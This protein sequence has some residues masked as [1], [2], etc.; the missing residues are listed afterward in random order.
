MQIN[1]HVLF[2]GN[3]LMVLTILFIYLEDG[4]VL[5]LIIL[6]SD[7]YIYANQV[8]EAQTIIT[9]KE[10]GHQVFIENLLFHFPAPC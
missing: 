8:K 10:L 9:E 2:A 6:H 3:A 5:L 7:I 4:S 1:R